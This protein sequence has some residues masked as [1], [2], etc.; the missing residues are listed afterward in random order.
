[1]PIECKLLEKE[2][3]AFSRCP[4]CGTPDPM[5]MRGQVQR[6]KRFLRFLW[7]RHYCA[8]ICQECK[9][10]IGWESPPSCKGS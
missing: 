5:F 3:S 7:K 1:M 6:S 4:F 8:V 2:P 10:I 9:E